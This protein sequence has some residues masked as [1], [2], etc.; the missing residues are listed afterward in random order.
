MR[1][2]RTAIDGVLILHPQKYGDAR[3]FVSETFKAS[4]LHDAGMTHDWVQENH[5]YSAQAGTVRGLHFQAPPAAQAKLVR[6]VR[7]A[8][9]DVAVDLRRASPSY[10]KHVDIELSAENFTQLYVPPGFA[11]GFCTLTDDAEV[12]YKLS[13][14]YAP[15]HEG[16]VLWNDPA[17]GIAWPDLA[18]IT[19]PRDGQWPAFRDFVSPF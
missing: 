15:A 1:I 13:A 7:G 10:G 8:I 14:E 5:S 2:E 18:P 4:S 6:V 12:L 9:L 3:G 19:S 17:L 11:H 16:G